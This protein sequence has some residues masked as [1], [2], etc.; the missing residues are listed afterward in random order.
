M[1]NV[2]SKEKK[3]PDLMDV[4]Y[5]PNLM[6]FNL[7]ASACITNVSFYETENMS[8]QQ[9]GYDEELDHNLQR[10]GEWYYAFLPTLKKS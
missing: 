7:M 8:K 5:S 6:N 2:T 1:E 9:I 10:K 4:N 3:D